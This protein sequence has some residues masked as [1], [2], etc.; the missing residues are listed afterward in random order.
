MDSSSSS[1]SKGS[2]GAGGTG[3]GYARLRGLRRWV[4]KAQGLKMPDLVFELHVLRGL[5][6]PEVAQVLD[7]GV[8]TVRAHWPQR[9]T[10][11]AWRA[12]QTEAD[13]AG[14]REHIGVV[15]WETVAATFAEGM[16][17]AKNGEA[18]APAE[19]KPAMLS[20]RIRAL[21]EIAQ[22]YDVGPKK[23]RDDDCVPSVCATPEEIAESVREWR[24]REKVERRCRWL[25][26]E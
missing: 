11:G 17:D 15:L 3:L 23:K 20:I 21:K 10:A 16:A 18:G 4:G 14:L 26:V 13:V 9:G 1:S 2:A 5:S 19:P 6:L 22:L 12:P 24:E 7:L 8:E 25:N